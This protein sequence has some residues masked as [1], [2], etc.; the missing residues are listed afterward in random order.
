MVFEDGVL[1]NSSL[2]DYRVP[3][4]KDMPARMTGI[5]VENARRSRSVRREGVR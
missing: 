4:I 2:L 5:I 1:I 3:R